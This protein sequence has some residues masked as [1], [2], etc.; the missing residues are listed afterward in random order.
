MGEV[1]RARD[2][3]LGREVAIKTLPPS[4]KG[5]PARLSRFEREARL[6]ASLNHP[7]I[8]TLHGLEQHGS[9]P[10]LVMELVE[11]APLDQLIL[12][13]PLSLQEALRI[14]SQVAEALEAAHEKGI[15]HR[16]LKP[17]NVVVGPKGRAKVLDFGIA[18]SIESTAPT[19]LPG[20][21][22]ALGN[23]ALTQ[24]GTSLGT[25]PYMSPEQVRGLD[26]D[27]RTDIWAFG[28][29]LYELLAGKRAF[30]SDSS[31]GA[32]AAVLIKDPD[33]QALPQEVPT[34]LLVLLKSCLTKTLSGRIAS[35]AEVRA[36]LDHVSEARRSSGQLPVQQDT[37]T[38]VEPPLRAAPRLSRRARVAAAVL[39]V[40]A[41]AA[42]GLLL[43]PGFRGRLGVPHA[44]APSKVTSLVVLPGRVLG[45][46]ADLF[47][48]DAVP[49][50]VSTHLAQIE[51]LETK[52][53]P[54][55]AEFERAGRDLQ[56]IADAYRVG[57]VVLPTVTVAG[58]RLILNLQLVEIPSRVVLWTRDFEDRRDRYVELARA[59][60]EGIRL[61]LRP[62]APAPAL[63]QPADVARTSEAELALHQGLFLA[64]LYRRNGLPEDFKRALAAL[65]HALELDPAQADAPAEIA[66][67]HA[68]RIVTGV[69]PQEIVPLVRQWARRALEID[70]RSSRAWA[71][72]SEA[73]QIDPQGEYRKLLDDSLKAATFGP[74]EGYAH[75]RLTYALS[76]HSTLLGLKAS[77]RAR[78]L[79]P[80][81]LTSLVADA[82]LLSTISRVDEALHS[83]EQVLQVEPDMPFAV[84]MDALV[85]TL[86]G[87]GDVALKLVARLEPVAQSGRIRPE[88]LALV[89]DYATFE[90][91]SREGDRKLADAAAGRLLR[92]ARGERQFPRW[93]SATALVAPLLARHGRTEEALELMSFRNRLGLA[94][95]YEFLLLNRDLQPLRGDPRFQAMLVRE[96]ARFEEMLGILSA[97]RRRGEYPAY[98]DPALDNLLPLLGIS[99][100]W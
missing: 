84:L 90:K 40:A 52:V 20:E 92:A 97:A 30:Q 44:D 17:S 69:P 91:A 19:L 78:Q 73:E 85:E 50:T 41:L 64:S 25:P 49:N 100:P 82:V 10:C 63:A 48:A 8:A 61:A 68:A 35:M 81:D 87:H 98:L 60:A 72:L 18:K 47:L 71:V 31:A 75:N 77:E 70:P 58:D 59:A 79:D 67:L 15:V 29:L 53:P 54:T 13:G 76:R 55:N 62:A 86:A 65:Q 80:L 74:G 43:V 26:V 14:G 27:S 89:R 99:R 66:R 36:V 57:A 88:W 56:R 94:E 4:M 16:D 6:L 22:E 37:P 11:G 45:G 21:E 38:I 7:N 1:Y 23:A 34:A 24:V 83:I 28:C 95:T 96:R 93:E 32:L 33:W 42:G 5:D 3:V 46:E 51:G 39:L 9:E 2:T 12:S